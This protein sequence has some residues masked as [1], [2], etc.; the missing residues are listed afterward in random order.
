[1]GIPEMLAQSENGGGMESFFNSPIGMILA[2]RVSARFQA[3]KKEQMLLQQ[4]QRKVELAGKFADQIE[5]QDPMAAA[6]IRADPSTMDNVFSAFYN[7][8]KQKEA[9]KQGFEYDIAKQQNQADLALKQKEAESMLPGGVGAHQATMSKI[10]ENSVAE[11]TQGPNMPGLPTAG[12]VASQNIDPKRMTMALSK[13][14]ALP[15]LT[16][17]NAFR[18]MQDPKAAE[19][20]IDNR[21]AEIEAGGRT[22][23]VLENGKIIEKALNTKTGEYDRVIGEVSPEGKIGDHIEVFDKD[24][25][26]NLI[27]MW[28]PATR[29]YTKTIGVAPVK[30]GYSVTVDPVTGQPVITYGGG[31]K[32]K[33]GPTESE[34]K[35]NSLFEG[36]KDQFTTAVDNWDA[37]ALPRNSIGSQMGEAGK[38]AMTEEGQR[39][40]NAIRQVAQ[41]YIYA[42]SGQ[43]APDSEVLRIMSLVMPSPS[44]WPGTRAD[45]K[46]LLYSMMRSIK[47]RTSE[48]LGK[49]AEGNTIE[50][51]PEAMKKAKVNESL[52][53]ADPTAEIPPMDEAAK[54]LGIKPEYWA[55][56]PELWL[57]EEE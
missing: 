18:L 45:K 56:H 10:L 52:R 40:T 5:S 12:E 36:A 7:A 50:Y 46:I 9:L 23:K 4:Y 6:M 53:V 1:M 57:D 16:T 8:N 54:K 2:P 34:A 49:D 30:G 21:R 22:V 38:Y 24:S 28:E 44:D 29:D 32:G 48:G 33:D 43:Q 51:T 15:D 27:K 11:K 47:S 25:G 17:G 55:K 13:D 42:L 41:N 19:D 3:A 26:E 14:Y 35:G 39:A 31:A 20:L 37:L